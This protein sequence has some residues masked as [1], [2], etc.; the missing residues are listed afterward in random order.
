MHRLV[1]ISLDYIY[2]HS[3]VLLGFAT[4][5]THDRGTDYIT[6]VVYTSCW[7]EKNVL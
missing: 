4:H 6:G 2:A 5:A 7:Q 1:Y 3:R